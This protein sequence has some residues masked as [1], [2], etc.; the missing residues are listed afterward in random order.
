MSRALGS[1]VNFSRAVALTQSTRLAPWRVDVQVNGVERAYVL[2]FDTRGMEYEYNVLRA[3]EVI[4]LPLPTPRAYGLDM[5]GEVLG[6]PC[7][8]SDFID[9]ES[10]LAPMLA[11]NAWAEDLYLDTVCALQAITDDDLRD[12][13]LELNR[14]TAK[15]VLEDAY[16]SLQALQGRA[17]PFTDA[18]YRKLKSEMPDLPPLRFSNGDLWLDNFIV[19]DRTLA[20]VIDF[21]GAG[22]SDPVYEFLLPFFVSPELCGRGIEER[23]CRRIGVDPATLRWYRGLEFFETWA[24]LLKTGKTFV[25]HT[26]ENVETNL[27]KWLA[28]DKQFADG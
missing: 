27:A 24:W 10:L 21:Q 18:I 9:G 13:A 11:G 15:E 28:E 12:S 6:V 16:A 26:A 1:P 23:F 7:F 20:G 3:L 25:H 19:K 8:L 2:Q 17:L 14:T 22:F 5:Q 4:P